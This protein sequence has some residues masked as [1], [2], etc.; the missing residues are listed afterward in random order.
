[1]ARHAPHPYAAALFYDFMIS[2]EGQRLIAQEGRVVV[3][4]K[5]EPIYPRMKE[6]QNLLGTPRVQINTLEQNA[7]VIKDG[8][9]ILDEIILKRKSTG[10]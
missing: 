8:V 10:H 1:M 4:P 5:V 3:H 7:R 9:Q 6:L 2:E